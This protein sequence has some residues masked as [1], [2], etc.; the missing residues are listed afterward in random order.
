MID[1][2]FFG[3]LEHIKA[4]NSFFCDISKTHFNTGQNMTETVPSS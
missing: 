2:Q 4:T 3:I 1:S